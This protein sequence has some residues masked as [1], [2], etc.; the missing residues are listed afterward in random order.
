[1]KLREVRRNYGVVCEEYHV[2]TSD[3]VEESLQDLHDRGIID[4]KSLT[5][6]GINGVSAES[7]GNF[8]DHLLKKVKQVIDDL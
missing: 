5:E 2:K 4:I 3:D 1:M 7:L 8:L 6:I